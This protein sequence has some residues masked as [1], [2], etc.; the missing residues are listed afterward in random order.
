MDNATRRAEET[1]QDRHKRL[2]KG[3][4]NDIKQK[5]EESVDE[6]QQ[7]LEKRRSGYYKKDKS[8]QNHNTIQNNFYLPIIEQKQVLKL[9]IYFM[10]LISIQ[11]NSAQF[12][13]KDGL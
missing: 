9:L 3:R 8:I 6:K 11:F 12:V 1:D 13:W 2:P 7:R 4:E 5:A 10:S